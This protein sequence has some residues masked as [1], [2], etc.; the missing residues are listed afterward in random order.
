MDVV[1]ENDNVIGKAGRYEIH[2]LGMWHRGVHVLVFNSDG[3]LLLPLRSSTKD[4]FPETYDCSVSEH[5]KSGETF[6]GAAIRGLREELKITK[7]RLR[8]L[9]KFR[10]NYGP[11]DNSVATLYECAC[12]G[13]VEIEMDEVKEAKFFP[14]DKIKEML[15][16]YESKF[17]PWNREILKW[18]FHLP[19]KVEEIG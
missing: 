18:Y 19:S 8:R 11:N 10:M 4:K 1:D 6:Q 13:E 16:K 12:E 17:A 14:L 7:L 3:E 9:L 2:R 5:V 15:T